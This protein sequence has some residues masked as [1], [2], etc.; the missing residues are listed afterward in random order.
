MSKSSHISF[1]ADVL[2]QLVIVLQCHSDS[3][4]PTHGDPKVISPL[5]YAD[6][7]QP[8]TIMLFGTEDPGLLPSKVNADV[9]RKAGNQCLL[10]K[11]QRHGF[12]NNRQSKYFKLTLSEVDKFLVSLGWLNPK[13]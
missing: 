11:D 9:T 2:Y 5:A 12:F 10:I 1:S 7:K 6:Q 4:S 13:S 3:G 8:P